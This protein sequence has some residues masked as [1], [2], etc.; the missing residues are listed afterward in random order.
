M[1][2]KTGPPIQMSGGSGAH[3]RS[4]RLPPSCWE[5]V[6]RTQTHTHT[7][8]HRSE[9]NPAA[10]ASREPNAPNRLSRSEGSFASVTVRN[11]VE[12]C[13][14]PWGFHS[15]CQ[16]GAQSKV[17]RRAKVQL[18]K[19]PWIRS[20]IDLSQTSKHP[21]YWGHASDTAGSKWHWGG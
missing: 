21:K 16:P 4:E 1:R 15:T 9:P 14:L 18:S 12:D 7:H 8:T 6:G 19:A 11:L 2:R 10:A 3:R 20:L 17:I 13:R 5:E